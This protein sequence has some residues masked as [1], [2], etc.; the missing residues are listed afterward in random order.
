LPVL[1]AD[2]WKTSDAEDAVETVT[3]CEG[4]AVAAEVINRSPAGVGCGLC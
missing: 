1:D 2:D 3:F 4:G